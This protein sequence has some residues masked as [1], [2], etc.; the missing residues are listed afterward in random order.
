MKRLKYFLH[1]LI[2]TNTKTYLELVI[3]PINEVLMMFWHSVFCELTKSTLNL[4]G[5]LRSYGRH[6]HSTHI[7]YNEWTT[8]NVFNGTKL[9][10]D[11]FYGRSRHFSCIFLFIHKYIPVYFPISSWCISTIVNISSIIMLPKN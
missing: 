9:N 5:R 11:I 1:I 6:P 3:N 4:S 10:I 8:T 2:F 7:Q